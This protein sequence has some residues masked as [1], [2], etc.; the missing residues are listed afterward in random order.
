MIDVQMNIL[1][2]IFLVFFLF[3]SASLYSFTQ[4]NKD[5]ALNQVL[6]EY[7]NL[8]KSGDF[9]S[10]T[11][12]IYPKLFDYYPEHLYFH[13]YTELAVDTG[14]SFKVTEIS[15]KDKNDFIKIGSTKYDVIYYDCEYNITLKGLVLEDEDDLYYVDKL[16]VLFELYK[17]KYGETNTFLDKETKSIKVIESRKMLA[18]KDAAKPFWKL[19]EYNKRTKMIID[20]FVPTEVYSLMNK[21]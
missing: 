13:L 7:F 11:N 17:R 9:E 1:K 10:V 21:I 16:D 4:P 15:L 6:D 12:F 18:I 2:K 14:I 5:A 3:V 19:M 8:L 20:I